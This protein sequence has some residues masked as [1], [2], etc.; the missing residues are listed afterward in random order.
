MANATPT[1]SGTGSDANNTIEAL[2]QQ[3]AQYEQWLARLDTTIDKAPPGVRD[4]VRGDYEGRLGRVID[5]LRGYTA[6]IT[7]EL[8]H[9]RGIENRLNTERL[10]TE[11][12]L[13]EAEVRHLVGEYGEDEWARLSGESERHLE[14]LR[15]ELGAVAAEIARLAEVQTLIAAPARTTAAPAPMPTPTV[16][17]TP[18]SLEMPLQLDINEPTPVPSAVVPTP[19]PVA[20]PVVPTPAPVYEAEP[21]PE[22]VVEPVATASP[23]DE[24]AFLKS[25]SDDERKP[26]APRRSSG[27]TAAAAPAQA[28]KLAEPVA[29]P[30]APAGS[31]AAPAAAGAGKTAGMAKTL[32]CNECGTFNRQTEWYCERCGA[33]LAAL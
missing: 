13:A 17:E 32:K 21:R 22:P 3:R 29:A 12:A 5:E 18:V 7:Q 19:A 10:K 14:R 6:T 11:E 28:A 20:Q 23:M 26:A 31:T 15:N 33:E 1:T 27:G 30:S 8:E 16:V 9:H 24:L 2:L 25:V 4:R